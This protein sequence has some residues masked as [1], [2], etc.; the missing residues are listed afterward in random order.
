LQVVGRTLPIW[1]T[2]LLLLVTHVPALR[3]QDLLR[4]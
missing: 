1:L 4:R 3:L 2:V